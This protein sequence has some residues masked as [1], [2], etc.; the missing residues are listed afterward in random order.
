MTLGRSSSGSAPVGHRLVIEDVDG[1]DPRPAG[2][3]GR[4]QRARVDQ[5]GAA[6]VDQQRVGFHRREVGGRMIPRVA[7]TRRSGG[8][9]RRCRRRTPRGSPPRGSRHAAHV[10]ARPRR[11]RR[12]RSSRTPG[13]S[14]RRRARSA[15]SRRSRASGRAACGRRRSATCRPAARPPDAG[16][17][18]IAARIRR[19]GQLGGGIARRR[20]GGLSETMI[21][22]SR[23]G[24]DVDVRVDAALAD[25]AQ[26]RQPLEQRGVDARPFPDEHERLE[27]PPAARPA[28]STVLQMIG[29]HRD[30]V[31]GELIEAGQRPDRVQIVVEDGDLHGHDGRHARRG[32]HR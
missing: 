15:R 18:R 11:P 32:P 2:T 26:P 22:A 12:S 4:E 30:L 24:G 27:V 20:R 13:R 3:Q 28:A 1:G 10:R 6:G 8:T 29:E 21:A 25:Q 9:A 7:G 31:A 19:P 23:A 5:A 16:I 17:W 14:R